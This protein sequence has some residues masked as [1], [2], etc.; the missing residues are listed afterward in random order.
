VDSIS[1]SGFPSVRLKRQEGHRVVWGGPSG[2]CEPMKQTLVVVGALV[3]AL[4]ACAPSA[5][6]ET[7][8]VSSTGPPPGGSTTVQWGDCTDYVQDRVAGVHEA[9]QCVVDGLQGQPC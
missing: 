1:T 4:L 6:A 3:V 8:C 2:P 7:G 9:A 5:T